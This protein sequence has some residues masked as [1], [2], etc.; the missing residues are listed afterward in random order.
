LGDRVRWGSPF[1]FQNKPEEQQVVSTAPLDI[2]LGQLGIK[3]PGLVFNKAPI[4]VHRF[5]VPG[6][7]L[8]QTVYYPEPDYPVYRASITKDLLIIETTNTDGFVGM[9]VICRSF[10]IDQGDLHQLDHTGQRYGK[11]ADVDNFSRKQLMVRLTNEYNI[12]SLGRFATWRNILLDDVVNDALVI[13]KLMKATAYD[14]Q[15]HLHK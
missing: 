4:D 14:R 7:D 12:F 8:Y 9:D 6:C 15:L 10:G 11:I 3:P 1:D 5:R 13:K 2:V